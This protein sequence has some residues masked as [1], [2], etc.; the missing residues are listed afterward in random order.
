MKRCGM[1]RCAVSL[2]PM[3]WTACLLWRLPEPV[4]ATRSEST[5]R[6]SAGPTS[7]SGSIRAVASSVSR[8]RKN[9]AR[10]RASRSKRTG[11]PPS[12]ITG[13]PHRARSD[14]Y[15]ARCPVI[16]FAPPRVKRSA[17]RALSPSRTP[18][19]T[20]SVTSWRRRTPS[21]VPGIAIS[22]SRLPARSASR[23]SQASAPP[24]IRASRERTSTTDP[25]GNCSP[26]YGEL[27]RATTSSRRYPWTGTAMTARSA[28]AS[29]DPMS[30]VPREEAYGIPKSGKTSST[31]AIAA[32]RS[33]KATAISPGG[34]PP[35][36]RSRTSCATALTSSSRSFRAVMQMSPPQSQVARPEKRPAI[37]LFAA[38]PSTT[39]GRTHAPSSMK[40]AGLSAH[41]TT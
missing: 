32:G 26:M 41:G 38:E 25:A 6:N 3:T 29:G 1:V 4:P 20:V 34:T 30:A 12:G 28:R 19:I 2:M 21:G 31:Y 13:Q 27:R 10:S 9:A 35:A 40:T 8:T 18:A 37:R 7:L 11:S 15:A 14:R 16:V 36:M 33:G 39:S 23:S 24:V 5:E 17:K 22:A